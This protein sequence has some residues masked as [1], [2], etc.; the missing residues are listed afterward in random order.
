MTN[1]VL[2]ASLA[3]FFGFG[4]D[5]KSFIEKQQ[6]E[7]YVR[8]YMRRCMEMAEAQF[9]SDNDKSK[10][11]MNYCIEQRFGTDAERRSN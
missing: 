2:T 9:P 5:C 1:V 7:K 6:Y 3:C 4:S 8:D 10:S 11:A